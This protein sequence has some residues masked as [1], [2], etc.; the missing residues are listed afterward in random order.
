NGLDAGIVV[1]KTGLAGTYVFHL[2]FAP[3][4][5]DMIRRNLIE[6]G[7]DPG[8]PTAPELAIALQEQLGLKLQPAKG[9]QDFVVIEHVERPKTDGPPVSYAPVIDR[10]RR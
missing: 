7:K 10:R 8:D 2:L 1:D 4:P 9:P 6:A 5:D 3:P